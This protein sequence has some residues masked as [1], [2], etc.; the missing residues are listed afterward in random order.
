MVEAGSNV[1]LGCPGMT[2]NTYVVQ[3]EWRCQ[4]RCGGQKSRSRAPTSADSEDEVILL[5][6]VKD[7]KTRVLTSP[8][9]ISLDR[10]MFG[11]AFNPVADR[12]EGR[13]L[14]LI[15]N[16]PVPDAVIK[17]NVLGRP[18]HFCLHLEKL[19]LTC[20]DLLAPINFSGLDKSINRLR[21]VLPQNT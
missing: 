12:D 4:G 1:S 6:Y 13:Y 9:R 2:R 21:H 18:N 3:L 20:P 8:D 7:Q 15:N 11:L 16:R 17:L 5:K 19:Q 14:C 10:D